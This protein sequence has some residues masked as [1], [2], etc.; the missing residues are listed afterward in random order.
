MNTMSPTMSPTMYPSIHPTTYYC[1][2]KLSFS[3]ETSNTSNT[4]NTSKASYTSNC[5]LCR[6]NDEQTYCDE[7]FRLVC[8]SDNCT[9]TFDASANTKS[10]IC[11]SCFKNIF[12]RLRPSSQ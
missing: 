10:H 1:V 12:H 2:S 4:S 6:Y 5:S 7:C 3:S 9:M 11:T 8:L